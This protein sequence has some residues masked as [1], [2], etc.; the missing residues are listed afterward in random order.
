[1]AK[2]NKNKKQPQSKLPVAAWNNDNKQGQLNVA[3]QDAMEVFKRLDKRIKL[4]TPKGFQFDY[5]NNIE[6]N[7]IV[8]PRDKIPDRLLRLVEGRNSVVGS[9]ITLRIQ[10]GYEYSEITHDKDV[11]GWEFALKDKDATP[12]PEQEKQKL[13]LENFMTNL[14]I[15]NDPI[16]IFKRDSFKSLL[17][18]F[19]KR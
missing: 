1:M 12:T 7:N 19:N 5:L 4:S 16:E 3:Y 13:F 6:Y 11:P 9:V 18:K 14:G 8:Y 17:T 15:D 2:K 10:Q